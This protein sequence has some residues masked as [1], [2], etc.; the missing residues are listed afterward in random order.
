[1]AAAVLRAEARL[2]TSIFAPGSRR[3]HGVLIGGRSDFDLNIAAG[4]RPRASQ[5]IEPA[6]LD[7]VDGEVA[8]DRVVDEE[9]AT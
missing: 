9:V 1:M 4:D 3:Q 7:A 5:E 8:R 2:V 6:D